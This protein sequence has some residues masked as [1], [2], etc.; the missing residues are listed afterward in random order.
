MRF[1]RV[2]LVVVAITLMTIALYWWVSLRRIP[3][4]R[5]T[6]VVGK[7]GTIDVDWIDL[8]RGGA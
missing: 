4:L 7:G 5:F 2:A 6:F 8:R 1:G 3:T